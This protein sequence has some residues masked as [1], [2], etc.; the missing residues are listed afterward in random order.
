MTKDEWAIIQ[1]IIKEVEEMSEQDRDA[2][3][4]EVIDMG[5]KA[6]GVGWL[7]EARDRMMVRH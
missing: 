7:K 3:I 5:V 4:Q 2:F 1:P 6:W